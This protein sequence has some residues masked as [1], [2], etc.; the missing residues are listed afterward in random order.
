MYCC[1]F[2][3]NNVQLPKLLPVCQCLSVCVIVCLED[4]KGLKMQSGTHTSFWWSKVN[5]QHLH[6]S[7]DGQSRLQDVTIDDR[8]ELQLF[9]FGITTLMEN[10]TQHKR[11]KTVRI[12]ITLYN[13]TNNHYWPEELVLVILQQVFCSV[14]IRV[15]VNCSCHNLYYHGPFCFPIWLWAINL[16]HL[17]E[18]RI[19]T[20]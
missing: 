17:I 14:V 2:F 10:S 20:F 9:F 7:D 16:V 8:P 4:Q 15:Y 3:L 19:H 11:K 12:V 6:A 18:H 13:A 1:S 5:G